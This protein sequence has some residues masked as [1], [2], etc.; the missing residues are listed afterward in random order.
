VQ[1]FSAAF[2][3]VRADLSELRLEVVVT[4]HG[5]SF[6]TIK[7]IQSKEEGPLMDRSQGVSIAMWSIK[8]LRGRVSKAATTVS[9]N[10]DVQTKA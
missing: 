7:S 8:G 4:R 6:P 5:R 1:I 2:A 9:R 10:N 3:A